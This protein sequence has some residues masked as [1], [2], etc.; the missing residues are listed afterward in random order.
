MRKLLGGILVAVSLTGCAAIQEAAGRDGAASDFAQYECSDLAETAESE[1]AG[2]S[3]EVSDIR[4]LKAA[5]DHRDTYAPGD[6]GVVLRCSGNGKWTG[7]GRGRVVLELT[8]DQD[9]G[10]PWVTWEYGL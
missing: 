4:D 1:S 7:L 8:E 3:M 10:G 6:G 2:A 9:S 5:V